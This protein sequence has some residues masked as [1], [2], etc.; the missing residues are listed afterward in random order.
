[1]VILDESVLIK[2]QRSFHFSI[3][4][5]QCSNNLH[6][7]PEGARKYLERSNFLEELSM[8]VKVFNLELDLRIA[9]TK[10]HS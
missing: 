5:L 1:M 2:R 8:I 4:I 9:R 10:E 6:S 7:E 3:L